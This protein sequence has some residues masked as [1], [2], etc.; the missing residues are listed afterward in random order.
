MKLILP[1]GYLQSEYASKTFE[2]LLS[3]AERYDNWSHQ[4]NVLSL[5]PSERI[6]YNYN[7]AI[8]GFIG[9]MAMCYLLTDENIKFQHSIIEDFADGT[10]RDTDFILSDSG[11]K[12]DVKAYFP[13]F[14]QYYLGKTQYDAFAFTTFH[15]PQDNVYYKQG[16]HLVRNPEQ[17]FSQEIEIEFHG[18]ISV[19]KLILNPYPKIYKFKMT[20]M[21]TFIENY[22]KSLGTK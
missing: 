21:P 3:S 4:S 13:F 18:I 11:M 20:G 22:R 6:D 9:E 10:Q 17:I 8:S 5:T 1:K 15:L 19:S 2:H 12:I 14:K 16:L 7:R